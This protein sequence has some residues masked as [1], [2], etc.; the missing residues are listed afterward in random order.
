MLRDLQLVGTANAHEIGGLHALLTHATGLRALHYRDGYIE[1]VLQ[2]LPLALIDLVA[3]V[4]AGS[5]TFGHNCDHLRAL[6]SLHMYMTTGRFRFTTLRGLHTLPSRRSLTLY[7]LQ[8]E[9]GD[10]NDLPDATAAVL[11]SLSR[12]THL[13][14]C[15]WRT[16]GAL[17]DRL[18]QLAAMQSLRLRM[19]FKN[20]VALLRAAVALPALTALQLDHWEESGPEL[21]AM[22]DALGLATGLRALRLHSISDGDNGSAGCALLP[23]VGKL[24]QLTLLSL[25]SC[26]LGGAAKQRELRAALRSLP[27]LVTLSLEGDEGTDD[28]ARARFSTLKLALP[29]LARIEALELGGSQHGK[30]DMNGLVAPLATLTRLSR[31]GFEKNKVGGAGAALLGEALARLTALRDL[32]LSP[33]CW[34]AAAWRRCLNRSVDRTNQYLSVRHVLI[35][36]AC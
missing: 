20:Q 14:L 10:Y 5:S 17:A 13:Y 12:L 36:G 26:R 32:T 16:T 4:Q 8:E 28:S 2:Q 6:Q 29:R 19:C 27:L 18:P 11:C 33:T 23:A 35:A 1:P 30:G 34:A 21:S 25:E 22:A 3:R 7:G 9:V 24:S 15:G 31:L